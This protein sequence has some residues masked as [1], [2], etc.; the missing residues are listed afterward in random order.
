MVYIC[1]VMRTL[2]EVVNVYYILSEE[3]SALWLRLG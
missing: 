2:V 3:V 1:Y